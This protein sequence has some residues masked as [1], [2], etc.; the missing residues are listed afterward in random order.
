M[1]GSD[2]VELL[3]RD[4]RVTNLRLNAGS[5]TVLCP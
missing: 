2:S 5:G 3:T 4:R 1:E